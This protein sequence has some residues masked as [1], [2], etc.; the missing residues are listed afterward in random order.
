MGDGLL[1]ILYCLTDAF[2]RQFDPKQFEEEMKKQPL[3]LICSS[4]FRAVVRYV[5]SLNTST[6]SPLE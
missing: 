1:R 5:N 6:G 2:N 3:L 4:E